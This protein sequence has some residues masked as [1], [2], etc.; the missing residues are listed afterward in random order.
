MKMKR[1]YGSVTTVGIL[2]LGMPITVR[3]VERHLEDDLVVRKGHRGGRREALKTYEAIW[4]RICREWMSR[5]HVRLV[6]R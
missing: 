1:R 2:T 4:E 3:N 5:R 6:W